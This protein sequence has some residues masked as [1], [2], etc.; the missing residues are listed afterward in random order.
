MFK[1]FKSKKPANMLDALIVTIYGNPPP[2][3][4]ADV[5]AD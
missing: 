5:E 1:W 2:P 3:K 4:R